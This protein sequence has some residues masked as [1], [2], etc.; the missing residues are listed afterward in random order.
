[1][2]GE[3]TWLVRRAV[4]YGVL[5]ALLAFFVA[6]SADPPPTGLRV[7]V[8]GVRSGAAARVEVSGPGGVRVFEHSDTWQA[9][10]GRYVVKI[11][12]VREG[13]ATL[14]ATES[15]LTVEVR[16]STVQTV[17][18]AY[19]IMIPDHTKIAD[20]ANSPIVSMTDTEVTLKEGAY[21]ADLRPGHVIASGATSVVGDAF[22]ARVDSI[23]SGPDATR[24]ATVVQVPM[25][26]AL[27][28]M[29]L[30]V[31]SAPENRAYG[32]P[33]ASRLAADD[34]EVF[35]GGPS[36]EGEAWNE[37]SMTEKCAQN[38][39]TL[40]Y[41]LEN[42]GTRFKVT[43]FEFSVDPG[44]IDVN[45]WPPSADIDLPKPKLLIRFV[46]G[47]SGTARF[48]IE[49]TG[50]F[51]CKAEM[52]RPGLEL[53]ACKLSSEIPGLGSS[54]SATCKINEH[55]ETSFTAAG[56][57]EFGADI[58]L[59]AEL[60]AEVKLGGD[61]KP[62]NLK[63]KDPVTV[64]KVW[65]QMA[66]VSGKKT[67]VESAGTFNG[68]LLKTVGLSVGKGDGR[69]GIEFT[70]FI[71]SG[72][73]LTLD[74]V[75]G[76]LTVDYRIGDEFGVELDF[77]GDGWDVA[78]KAVPAW[79]TVPLAKWKFGAENRKMPE[80][81]ALPTG[82]IFYTQDDGESDLDRLYSK[83]G[84]SPAE[85]RGHVT[86]GRGT[87]ISPDGKRRVWVDT[88]GAPGLEPTAI[89][90]VEDIAG[91]GSREVTTGANIGGLCNRPA[92]SPDSRHVL[93]QK[94]ASTAAA[95]G[96]WALVDVDTGEE[97]MLDEP[98]GCYPVWSP[99]GKA[100][101]WY[102]QE[103]SDPAAY[104]AIRITDEKG[105]NSRFV[106]P[107]QGIPDLCSNNVIALSPGGTRAVVDAS[108]PDRHACGDGPGG[109]AVAGLVVDTATGKA[110]G[111]PLPGPIQTA[112]YLPDGT[113]LALFVGSKEF[114]LLDE[115]LT[116]VNRLPEPSLGGDDVTVLMYSHG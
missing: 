8:S 29:V 28:R 60:T 49:A 33:L 74:H 70:E 86:P 69:L 67:K 92:W 3:Q 62:L 103:P 27:P 106:P 104:A 18:A 100:I 14:R 16:E 73:K 17:R 90:S 109:N 85:R 82:A 7:E 84:A 53:T 101:A 32:R 111:N 56:G 98:T 99:D 50:S 6:C 41:G 94:T 5:V 12:P 40:K 80:R 21:A 107:V 89:L 51:T 58:K 11:E 66:A 57:F 83:T 59:A 48:G 81:P 71:S 39:P 1:M 76:E 54:A 72:A 25:L 77:W 93:F 113:L 47:V 2:A 35:P 96:V 46:T 114:V 38:G 79:F 87:A 20:A 95:A 78:R 43:E 65:G 61:N 116:V 112:A 115:D 97:V 19:R 34:F 75:D 102:D 37:V 68:G 63:S 88:S 36:I 91:N 52:D 26:F 110:V 30:R 44:K 64:Q 24:V 9:K 108:Q 45:I 4:V 23:R 15:R 13:D 42:L 22:A 31:Q 55:Y 105:N 10:P